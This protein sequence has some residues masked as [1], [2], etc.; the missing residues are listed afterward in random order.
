MNP[1]P[2][3]KRLCFR[4][5]RCFRCSLVLRFL[6]VSLFMLPVGPV[7]A[8]DCARDCLEGFADLLLTA[9]D[10]RDASLL[11]ASGNMRYTEN[12]QDIA[13]DDG[14][15]KTYV[16]HTDYHLYVA[17]PHAGQVV[18]MG[19]IQENEDQVIAHFRLK[20]ENR[21]IAE[22]EA[23]LARNATTAALENLEQPKAIFLESLPEAQRRSRE[24]M[25]AIT[26]AYFTGLD[27]ENSGANVPFHDDC[28][29]QENGM[30][31]ANN[32]DPDA[33]EM[34]RLGCKAQFDTGFSTI[35]TDVRERRFVALDEERGLSYAIVFFD[36]DG[37]PKTMGG[38]GGVSRDVPP[39]FRRPSTIM[40]GE[41]FKIVD[42]RI[43]Q[44]EA[45]IVSVPYG[46]PSGW[47]GKDL[48]SEG[49]L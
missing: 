39:A 42:G 35:V 37:T 22:V 32:P 29:R 27:T 8:Q 13:L 21:E 7:Q 30:L 48:V 10:A 14:L 33:G 45:I 23:L 31:L 24:E 25:V 15:W 4:C 47:E 40:I 11:P 41:L 20:V 9:L 49:L 12:G 43:R 36:H 44:I 2:G 26:D 1:A 18:F 34:Q 17:D 28:A 3:F 19:V 16:S 46:M 5:F 6:A 38:V